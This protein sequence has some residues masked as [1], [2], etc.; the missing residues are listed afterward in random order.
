MFLKRY[1]NIVQG[2]FNYLKCFSWTLERFLNVNCYFVQRTFKR[3]VPITFAKLY[4]YKKMF[5]IYIKKKNILN[6]GHFERSVS[7][8]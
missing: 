5:F 8:A 7:S 2:T 6:T 4:I 1:L 3:N